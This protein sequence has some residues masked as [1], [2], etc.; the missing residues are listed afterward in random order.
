M[1]H[2]IKLCVI[3]RLHYLKYVLSSKQ[4]LSWRIVILCKA[5]LCEFSTDSF[6]PYQSV[7]Y[8][9]YLNVS[10]IMVNRTNLPNRG[11]TNDVGGIISARSRKNTVSDSK[12]EIDKLTWKEG[13]ASVTG[14]LLL[15]LLL[16]MR[17]LEVIF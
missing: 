4:F 14:Y 17:E 3:I 10:K 12:M 6:M 15:L 11:T 5:V 1:E 16:L 8:Y 7:R 13:Q 9:T 2:P